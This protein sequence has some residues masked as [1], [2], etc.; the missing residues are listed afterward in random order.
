MTSR[1]C[2]MVEG[3]VECNME[4]K[5]EPILVE[6]VRRLNEQFGIDYLTASLLARRGAVRSDDVKFFLETDVSHLHNPF[7]FDE[8]EMFVDRILSARDDHEKV[9][10]FGY[11]DVDGITATVLLKKE[12]DAMG[13]E[14]EWRLPDGDA[15]Y[16]LTNVAIDAAIANGVTC[17]VTVDCGISNHAE[18]EY[19][20]KLGMDVLVTDHHLGG[21]SIPAATAV[22]NPKLTGS[23]YPFAHLAGCGVVAKCIWALRFA[24][25]DVYQEEML[26]LHALP[27]NTEPGNE[28]VIIEALSMKNLLVEDRI[29]EEVV[30]GLL[31][32]DQSRLVRFLDR[33]V[34][35][36]AFDVDTEMKLLRK[37][38]GKSVDIHVVELRPLI[39]AALPQTAG[40]SLFALKQISRSIR[41]MNDASELDVLVSLFCSYVYRK[42]PQLGKDFEPLFDL[43]AIGTIA[44]LMPMT[45]ENRIMVRTGLHALTAL[46]RVELKPLLM[47]Q[48]LAGKQ[49][50][51]TD[52][53][54]QITPVI[55]AAGRLGKPQVAANMLLAADEAAARTAC[56]ELL[57]M[58]KERQRQG[59]EYWDL[60][61]PKA[62][63]SHSD[64][65]G[66]FLFLEEP[67]ISRGMTGVLASRFL[68]K[69]NKPCLVVAHLDNDRVT[70]SMRSPSD[71]DTRAFLSL[72]GDLFLDYGGHFCAG[73]FSMEKENLPEFKKRISQTID[74]ME[75]VDESEQSIRIDVEL[76]PEYL[77]PNL[78]KLVEAFEPYGEGN[79]PL[80]FYIRNAKVEEVQFLNRSKSEGPGHVKLQVAY[81]KYRWPAVYWGAADLVGTEFS[82][83]DDIDMV[84]RLGRNYFRNNETLQLTVVALRRHE[85]TIEEIMDR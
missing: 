21:E 37:A 64:F 58:N 46:S 83:D 19:A 24:Q 62:I 9:C 55:N 34:P 77:N 65:N 22:I 28:T 2:G 38:F 44:D 14:N 80:Q 85:S 59:E 26:L 45:D 36:L 35:I 29:R 32:V 20:R 71:F 40:K 56:E 48:N 75:E 78:I 61:G 17:A 51:T 16:G 54:W 8:M 68:K 11:R 25:T 27:G 49:L 69:Y 7:M 82:K 63:K 73:G 50:S 18:V 53:G 72:F 12:L 84:F 70:G 23:G 66:K 15:P 47:A 67:S 79:P 43:V 41:Y 4:W 42:H 31:R 3:K 33:Q 10:I 5:K 52:V 30:P 13:I 6:D 76:P 57:A 1:L 60:L 81:G 39:E 74:A